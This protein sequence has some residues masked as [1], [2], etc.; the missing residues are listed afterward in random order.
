M[1]P[2]LLALRSASPPG[3]PIPSTSRCSC[4]R[5]GSRAAAARGRRA[6]RDSRPGSRSRLPCRG[7]T[8]A[9]SYIA[10][11]SPAGLN[12][13][14]GAEVARPLDV[15]GAGNGAAALAR[16][17]ACRCTPRRCACRGSRRPDRRA[18]SMHVAPG[19]EHRLV[20]ACRS[21]CSAAAARPRASRAGRPP[22]TRRS[23]RRAPARAD[24]RST[25]ETR[26]RA[27]RACPTVRRRPR[28]ASIASTPRRLNRWSIIH[29][30]A[31]SGAG[32]GVDERD[33]PE[34]EVHRAGNVPGGEVLGRP[35]VDEREASP[36]LFE[37]PAQLRGQ[38]SAGR[39]L[40][41]R[42]WRPSLTAH[43]TARRLYAA[44]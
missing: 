22:S 29:M 34:V 1:L 3:R 28:P 4:G 8:P 23:R 42:P 11:S 38:S 32:I 9:A 33:A 18:R 14:V 39:A 7:V 31:F 6:R 10:R 20:A 41:S 43:L 25:R 24:A 13:A 5:A 12:V 16:E 17:P 30:N 15:D 40:R 36:G 27:R 44:K 2:L 21:T 37:G 35:Q 26:T 19:R